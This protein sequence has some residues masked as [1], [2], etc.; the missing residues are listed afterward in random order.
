M[1]TVCGPFA[2]ALVSRGVERERITVLHNSVKP[3][4]ASPMEE[5]QR[6]R[7]SLGLQNDAV[8]LAV[9]RLSH[10]KAMADLL[11]AAAVMSKT[12]GAP[13]FRL[14]LVGDGPER[15]PLGRLGMLVQLGQS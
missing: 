4:V 6:L 14:V 1:V 5:V 11:K 2:D 12:N 8:I 9:G 7:Q 3:F 13:D 10:E 15:E